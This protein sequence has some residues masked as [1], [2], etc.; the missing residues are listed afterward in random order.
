M[1]IKI[2]IIPKYIEKCRSFQYHN[3]DIINKAIKSK[4]A[5]KVPGQ[6]F[7]NKNSYVRVCSFEPII[8]PASRILILGSIPGETSLRAHQYYAHPRNAF[9]PI[10]YNIW[11]PSPL[12]PLTPHLLPPDWPYKER[13]SFLLSK[14]LALWDVIATCTREGSLDSSVR[15][16]EI[17]AFDTFFA[18]YPNINKILFNGRKAYDMFSRH[19]GLTGDMIYQLLPSTSPTHASLAFAQKLAV[20]REALIL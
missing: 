8:S 13:L 5:I 9:W 19:H 2:L 18:A 7:S 11:A 4:K 12:P 15:A 17:Q 6:L 16:G 14:N 1:R 3:G 10:L 20:W